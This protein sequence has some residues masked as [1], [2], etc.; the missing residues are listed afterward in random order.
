M[1]SHSIVLYMLLQDL[2]SACSCGGNGNHLLGLPLITAINDKVLPYSRSLVG[3][4]LYLT[5][6]PLFWLDDVSMMSPALPNDVDKR[7]LDC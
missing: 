1:I 3:V 7:H 5:C 6:L 2:H 4:V